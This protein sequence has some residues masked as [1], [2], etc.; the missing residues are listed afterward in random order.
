MKQI[1]VG[2]K[3]IK[4]LK[5]KVDPE[6]TLIVVCNDRGDV[7]GVVHYEESSDVYYVKRSV[8]EIG[9]PDCF[10]DIIELMETYEE[11]GYSFHADVNVA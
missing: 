7:V 8:Q 9:D 10:G 3:K 2:T 11:R 1:K 4:V 5:P 6:V